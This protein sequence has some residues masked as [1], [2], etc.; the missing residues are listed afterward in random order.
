MGQPDSWEIT[1]VVVSAKDRSILDK[2]VRPS[3]PRNLC[4]QPGTCIYRALNNVSI[5][6]IEGLTWSS[7]TH[8]RNQSTSFYTKRRTTTDG[9][10]Y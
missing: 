5:L 8:Q 2:H 9:V 3:C 7:L 1:D 10:Q 6:D 4:R